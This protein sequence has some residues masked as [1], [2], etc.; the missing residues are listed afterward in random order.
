MKL[1]SGT[2]NQIK[3]QA[4]ALLESGRPDFDAP[5]TLAAVYWM[6]QLLKTEKSNE[7]ILVTAAYLH[8]IGY[9]RMGI[10]NDW[11]AVHNA[12]KD[13]MEHGVKLAAPILEKSGF[14]KSEKMDVL[15]L[16]GVHDKLEALSTPDEYLLFEADSLGQ[17]DIS[18]V[19]SNFDFAGRKKF[20]GS[21]EKKRLPRFRT[22][23]GKKFAAILF[24]KAKSF[25]LKEN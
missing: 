3:K 13:H 1:Q 21:F 4:L 5:H 6:K 18:R 20:I 16:I 2:E 15:R 23:T 9:S 7:K 19:C 14:S 8:D 11:Q 10:V 25:Y 24:P 17:I 22:K 12:K